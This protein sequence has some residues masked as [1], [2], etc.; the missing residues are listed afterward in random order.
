M[1]ASLPPPPSADTTHLTR[2]TTIASPTRTNFEST[3]A[4][5]TQPIATGLSP[6]AK[7]PPQLTPTPESIRFKAFPYSGVNDYYIN[8]E[9]GFLSVGGGNGGRY[10]LWLDDSL[11]VGHSARCDTF[12]NEPLSDEGDKFGVLGVEVWVLGD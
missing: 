2:T 12:G 11:D 4:T 3:A 7:S 9:G 6:T 8:C 10:G 1:L 5:A